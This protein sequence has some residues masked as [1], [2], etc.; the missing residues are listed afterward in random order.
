MND[1]ILVDECLSPDL[2]ATALLR[3]YYSTHVVYRGLQGT[4]D[5]DLI[6][7]IL[8]GNFIF[9]TNNG[10]DFLKIYSSLDIHPGLIIIV[11][12]CKASQ[13]IYLFNKILDMIKNKTDLINKVIEIYNDA[14]IKIYDLPKI[15]ISNNFNI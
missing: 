12:N 1:P 11:P 4:S 3:G 2:V 14:T 9:V 8:N 10:K 5:I 7:V 6:P 13:Q 15:N